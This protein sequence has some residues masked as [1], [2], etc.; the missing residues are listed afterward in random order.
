MNNPQTEA[1]I[2]SCFSRVILIYMI[3][4]QKYYCS[5]ISYYNLIPQIKIFTKWIVFWQRSELI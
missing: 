1:L 2:K 3:P 4:L 5:D